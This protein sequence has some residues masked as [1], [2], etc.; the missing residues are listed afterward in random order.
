MSKRV[1]P[2]DP[3]EEDFEDDPAEESYHANSEEED[4]DIPDDGT[5]YS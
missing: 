4:E 2:N 3:Q 5:F 1:K